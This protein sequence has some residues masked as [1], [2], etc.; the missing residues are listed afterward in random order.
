MKICFAWSLNISI[1]S[2]KIDIG[3]EKYDIAFKRGYLRLGGEG[4]KVDESQTL[5]SHSLLY[6]FTIHQFC[7][8]FRIFTNLIGMVFGVHANRYC[9]DRLD[10]FESKFE[11]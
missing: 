2:Q 11:R 6:F 3:N 1:L 9:I 8:R 4:V 10:V 5:C 7:H